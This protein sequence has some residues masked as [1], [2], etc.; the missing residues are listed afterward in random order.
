SECI[1]R[2][3]FQAEL[4]LARTRVDPIDNT[5]D[6]QRQYKD[7]II[8]SLKEHRN[9]EMESKLGRHHINN[10]ED[11]D[12]LLTVYGSKTTKV[13]LRTIRSSHILIGQLDVQ[14][15]SNVKMWPLSM[16]FS[17]LHSTVEEKFKGRTLMYIGPPLLTLRFP[18][19]AHTL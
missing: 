15:I 14:S 4:T 13:L 17:K 18:I 8:N 12:S 10:D 1:K 7:L 9:I 6:Y 16:T 11:K 3:D 5:T 19:L 2:N